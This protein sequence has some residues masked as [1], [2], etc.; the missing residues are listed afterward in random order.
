MS[1]RVQQLECVTVTKTKDNVQLTVKVAVQYQVEKHQVENAYYKLTNVHSQINS[2]VDDA[3][4]TAV[5]KQTLDEAFESKDHIAHEVKAG[6]QEQMR[7]YGFLIM[8]ALVTD[9]SPAAQVVQAMNEI[10]TARRLREA[11]TEKAEANKILKVTQ[12]EADAKAAEWAGVGIANQRKAIVHGMRES[13]ETFQKEIKGT[14]SS[15]VM[16]MIMVTQYIDMLKELG[17]NPNTKTVFVNNSPGAVQD[18]QAQLRQ[19]L[20][21]GNEVQPTQYKMG[22]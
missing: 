7:A 5:P 19:A 1:L 11:A 14:S 21:Q 10:N 3:V 18:I 17:S 13:V 15:E 9:L 22:P 6:L 8:N 12:A 16:N 2:Y 20:M 4:R